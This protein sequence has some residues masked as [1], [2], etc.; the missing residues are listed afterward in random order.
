MATVW[1]LVA[2]LTLLLFVTVGATVLGVVSA[3]QRART[4]ADAAALAAAAAH[5][6]DLPDPCGRAVDLAVRNG[7]RVQRC[8]LDGPDVRV[9]VTVAVSGVPG[10]LPIPPATGRARAGPALRS[11]TSRNVGAIIVVGTGGSGDSVAPLG[12]REGPAVH[13]RAASSWSHLSLRLP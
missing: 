9:W 6:E 1:V 12:A 3:R 2:A 5:L 4:A 8:E 11:V 7:A 10:L 13:R